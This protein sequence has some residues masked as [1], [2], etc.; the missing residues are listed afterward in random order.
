M[1]QR[2]RI[3]NSLA[4]NGKAWAQMFEKNKALKNGLLYI[5]EHIPG[6][7][8]VMKDVT[9]ILEM[10]YWPSYNVPATEYVYN[11]SGNEALARKDGVYMSYDLAPRARIFR[12]D[13]NGVLSMKDNQKIMRYNNYL[14]DSLEENNV[15]WA[16]MS[17]FDLNDTDPGAFGG[18][19]SKCADLN[20][21]KMLQAVDC[22]AQNGPTHDSLPPFSFTGQ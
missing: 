2:V 5:Y 21:L 10:G 22:V 13:A 18:I 4:N 16:I 19:D 8:S 12:R 9:N 3:S 15:G 11:V 20:Y 7:N 1:G 6:T 17:R 14:N